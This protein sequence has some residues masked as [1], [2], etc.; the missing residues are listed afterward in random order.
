MH[1]A[2]FGLATCTIL[3]PATT[4]STET[5]I[6]SI[7]FYSIHS[8]VARVVKHAVHSHGHA[9]LPPVLRP[10]PGFLVFTPQ[11]GHP[12]PSRS[13]F[14]TSVRGSRPEQD[15]QPKVMRFLSHTKNSM[16]HRVC[17]SVC[18]VQVQ[19]KGVRFYRTP[20]KEKKTRCE[21]CGVSYPTNP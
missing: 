16:C 14:N 10:G 8:T 2:V 5:S 20:A 4:V 19:G 11:C 15:S 21:R 13:T 7:V 17:A 1:T 12:F 9:R 6:T 18:N 3:H